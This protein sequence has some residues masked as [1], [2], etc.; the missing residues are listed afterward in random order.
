MGALEQQ[1]KFGGGSR[2]ARRQ[3]VKAR[4]FELR[5]SGEGEKKRNRI[6]CD[7]DHIYM[8]AQRPLLAPVAINAC[9]SG[10]C[11]WS[12]RNPAAR[13]FSGRMDYGA[14]TLV[15]GPS[16]SGPDTGTTA[17]FFLALGAAA[18]TGVSWG[19]PVAATGVAPADWPTE[20]PGGKRRWGRAGEYSI[21]EPSPPT[22]ALGLLGAACCRASGSPSAL[23]TVP[24]PWELP[25]PPCSE[26]CVVTLSRKMEVM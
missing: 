19:L 5:I 2:G 15:F 25:P 20:Q 6:C 7:L 10:A 26:R 14:L 18:G 22:P 9:T 24:V 16:T 1:Q 4:W 13:H 11:L 23:L 8:M 12:A 21:S 3:R 17:D